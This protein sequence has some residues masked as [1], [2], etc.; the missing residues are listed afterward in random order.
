MGLTIGVQTRVASKF[1]SG[2]LFLGSVTIF[3]IGS[4]H[5][6]VY[7][8]CRSHFFLTSFL[9]HLSLM[10]CTVPPIVFTLCCYDLWDLPNFKWI[11]RMSLFLGIST[12]YLLPLVSIWNIANLIYLSV[13]SKDCMTSAIFDWNWFLACTT[14]IWSF[15]ALMIV[16]RFIKSGI[17]DW[18]ETWK[19][20][21]DERTLVS[22]LRTIFTSIKKPG[23][24]TS[25][26][27]DE[28]KDES[29][30]MGRL[31]HHERVL[32]RK[33]CGSLWTMRKRIA[34]PKHYSMKC[35]M[36]KQ[37]FAECNRIICLPECL[38]RFHEMCLIP[39]SKKSRICP[40]CKFDMRLQLVRLIG[41]QA[42]APKRKELLISTER[43]DN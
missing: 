42:Q 28:F 16:V 20:K 8:N 14:T 26:F 5:T 37:H 21:V 25:R 2:V 11:D 41:L 29:L 24:F 33:H 27:I 38:H 18:C 36:C 4:Y 3:G 15:F 10:V 13:K 7:K 23:V 39:H 35:M 30:K 40:V 17:G 34:D 22:H 31:R 1:I 32:L 19:E 9:L 6:N 12:C 43:S